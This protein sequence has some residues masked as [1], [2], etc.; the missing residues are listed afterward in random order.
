[1]SWE[2]LQTDSTFKHLK[3]KAVEMSQMVTVFADFVSRPDFDSWDPR[4]E[5]ENQLPQV[6]SALHMHTT[7][8]KIDKHVKQ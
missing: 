1:M 5:E 3:Y 2:P 7:H 4:M 6:A 8:D